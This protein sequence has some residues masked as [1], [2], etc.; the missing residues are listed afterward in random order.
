MVPPPQMALYSGYRADRWPNNGIYRVHNGGKMSDPFYILR[1]FGSNS[2]H[3]SR[4][5]DRPKG[6]EQRLGRY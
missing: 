1:T 6:R 3:H 4:H 5:A 2:L